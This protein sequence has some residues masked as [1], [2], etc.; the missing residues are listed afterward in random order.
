MKLC[1]TVNNCILLLEAGYFLSCNFSGRNNNN[2][3]KF[4][5]SFTAHYPRPNKGFQSTVLLFGDIK[6]EIVID[7]TSVANGFDASSA[8]A[9]VTNDSSRENRGNP[10]SRA[11]KK[12]D[13]PFFV[14]IKPPT[15]FGSLKNSKNDDNG[16]SDVDEISEEELEQRLEKV[17]GMEKDLEQRLSTLAQLEERLATLNRR[18][19]KLMDEQRRASASASFERRTPVPEQNPASESFNRPGSTSSSSSSSGSSTS[20]T[21]SSTSTTGSPYTAS[22]EQ[23][24]V[25]DGS[26]SSSSTSPIARSSGLVL[27]S[28][29]NDN[30]YIWNNNATVQNIKSINK[31]WKA[32]TPATVRAGSQRT[33]VYENPAF[34]R[35]L[36]LLKSKDGKPLQADIQVQQGPTNLSPPLY[37]KVYGEDGSKRTF[38]AFLDTPQSPNTVTIKNIGQIQPQDLYTFVGPDKKAGDE[39]LKA[40][41]RSGVPKQLL[42]GATQRY[43]IDTIVDSVVLLLKS[44][45]GTPINARIELLQENNTTMATT[46]STTPKKQVLEIFTEDVTDHPLL[47][48]IQTPGSEN[49]VN[50][51]NNS[52]FPLR[53]TLV[54]YE[55]QR[56]LILSLLP[57]LLVVDLGIVASLFWSGERLPFMG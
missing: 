21:R 8:V 47:L 56:P 46:S 35:V 37:M 10:S 12:I 27:S 50:V 49:L 23:A 9:N 13:K 34:E 14:S 52:P 24:S 54:E 28:Y 19:N 29:S 7:A 2:K 40:L 4:V 15:P 38:S 5:W 3:N 6:N 16:K 20:F 25:V 51:V 1:S 48:V 39:C 18:S 53:S 42:G 57:L 26:I 11:G 43:P 44:K 30:Y 36:I 33:W 45:E 41:R 22:T 32:L 55:V 31:I 17:S